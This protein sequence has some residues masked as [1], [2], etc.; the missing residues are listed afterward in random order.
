MHLKST[1]KNTWNRKHYNNSVTLEAWIVGYIPV[2]T[3]AIS[4][5]VIGGVGELDEYYCLR[6]GLCSF[7]PVYVFLK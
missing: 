5:I 7:L 4:G 2:L 3:F 1:F 6:A